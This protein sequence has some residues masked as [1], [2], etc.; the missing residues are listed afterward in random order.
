M[1]DVTL[2]EFRSTDTILNF[3]FVVGT[4]AG[5]AV[6]AAANGV[7]LFQTNFPIRILEMKVVTGTGAVGA[8]TFTAAYGPAADTP[9][10]LATTIGTALQAVLT[11]TNNLPITCVSATDTTPN[12]IVPAGSFVGFNVPIITTNTTT[13]VSVSVRYRSA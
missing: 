6:N 11:T 10:V 2:A 13:I 7:R 1:A 8:T 4:T 3:P 9:T 5:Q 12:H